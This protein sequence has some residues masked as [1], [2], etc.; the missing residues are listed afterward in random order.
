M[1]LV[2]LNTLLSFQLRIST[3]CIPLSSVFL[4]KQVWLSPT[5]PRR[6]YVAHPV[7]DLLQPRLLTL[8]NLESDKY[9]LR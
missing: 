2:L 8:L 6:T 1:T 3:R 5:I 9:R 7:Q 4:K